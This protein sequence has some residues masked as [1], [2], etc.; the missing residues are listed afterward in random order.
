MP[1]AAIPANEPVQAQREIETVVVG[2]GPAGLAVAGCLRKR[3]LPFV[4]LEREMQVGSSWH[5]HYERL[6]LHSDRRH[7]ALPYLDF[8]PGTPRYPS[9]E[10]VVAYLESFAQHFEIDPQLGAEVLSVREDLDSHEWI[11]ATRL[12]TYRSRQIVI[13]TGYNAVPNKPAWPGQERFGRVMHTSEYH[14]GSSFKGQRV[15]VVG[16]GNSGAEIALDL[17]E[18]GARVTLA[19]RGPVSVVPRDILGLPI[20]SVSLALRRLPTRIADALAAPLLRVTVGDL[21]RLGL[22]KAAQG[23]FTQIKTTG[24]IP[25]LDVGT[26]RLIRSGAI[27]IAGAIQALGE[28]EVVFADGSR[29]PFDSIVLATGFRPGLESFLQ[30]TGDLRH[31]AAMRG[32]SQL[33]GEDGLYFCGFAISAHGMLRDIAIEARSIAD[34]IARR[35]H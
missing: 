2:A 11:T 33:S 9:R 25:V 28:N 6:H 14:N 7:S 3:K 34:H 21:S 1:A 31:V 17:H 15:L 8:P 4:L 12:A 16:F 35:Q 22:R 10:Q 18:S 20:L 29:R 5:R 19:I 26:L 30:K 24:R 13:A 27:A 32:R 23:V